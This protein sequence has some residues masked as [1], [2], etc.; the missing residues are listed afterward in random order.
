LDY[1]CCPGAP[2][3]YRERDGI[4]HNRPAG[5]VTPGPDCIPELMLLMTATLA[6]PEMRS[7]TTAA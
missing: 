1:P 6:M 7:Q 4:S 3:Y 2:D 5:L